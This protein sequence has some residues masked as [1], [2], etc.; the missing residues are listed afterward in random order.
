MSSLVSLLIISLI[1]IGTVVAN[2]S[3]WMRNVSNLCH[4]KDK[5]GPSDKLIIPKHM[6]EILCKRMKQLNRNMH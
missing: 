4:V 2:A 5:Y 3:L 1:T 6:L